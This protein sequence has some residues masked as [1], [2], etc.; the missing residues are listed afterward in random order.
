MS[1]TASQETSPARPRRPRGRRADAALGLLL[2]AGTVLY[3]AA[4]P[5]NLGTPDEAHGLLS[6]MRVLHGEVM[7]RDVFE[8]ATPGFV[9]MMAGLFHLF[10]ASLAT[11]R[12]AAALLHG[13]T[14]L[15]LFLVCRG[16]GVRR[17][18]AW[19]CGFASLVVCQPMFPIASYHWLATFLCVLLLALCL[20]PGA[21]AS[22]ALVLGLCV[23][24]LI[25]VHQQRGLS[26][27]VGVAAVL[28]AE[29]LLA[30][31]DRRGPAGA[32]ARRALVVFAAGVTLIVGPL[33]AAL[34]ATAGFQPVWNALVVVPLVNYRQ[35]IGCAW[36]LDIAGGSR[37]PVSPYLRYLPATLIL[38]AL[39][40]LARSRRQRDGERR[41]VLAVLTALC[42]AAM[43]S[44]LYYPDSIH[45]AL[46]APLFLVAWSDA[47]EHG[48]RR[49]PTAA[50]RA[51]AAL[52]TVAVLLAGGAELS[53]NLIALRARYTIPYQSAFGRIDLDRPSPRA[54]AEISERLDADPARALYVY[55]LANY[56]HL[57][58][59]AH[60]PVRFAFIAPGYTSPDQ[61]DEI[62]AVLT[63]RRLPYVVVTPNVARA[64]DPVARFIREHYAPDP[65][66]APS[67]WR[68]KADGASGPGAATPGPL[69]QRR[70]AARQPDAQEVR[71]LGHRQTQQ[72][73]DL[74][75]QRRR[76]LPLER[77][78]LTLAA[79]ATAAPAAASGLPHGWPPG[80]VGPPDREADRRRVCCE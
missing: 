78:E 60:N 19:T 34:I 66:L 30:P 71:A 57:L 6:A 55:P 15:L 12:L 59:G 31:R 7:Y 3:L 44:I 69:S 14:A 36:G 33:L 28:I 25:A 24:L 21:A 5:L 27:G 8:P 80:W 39:P 26:M 76:A 13:A 1:D 77:G 42:G 53:D 45:L 17:S 16:L 23:G 68:R 18:L 9:L 75:A 41:R 52:V 51:A 67:L 35:S 4:H 40:L 70:T 20:R 49:L 73:A 50:G 72:A 32:A 2:F 62:V 56:L 63:A 43:L 37:S 74:I 61:L 22:R 79:S 11:A 58:L 46:I 64:D 47:I 48:L 54:W 10:G 29:P 38:T 65:T